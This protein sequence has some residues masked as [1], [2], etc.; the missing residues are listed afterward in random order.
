MGTVPRVSRVHRRGPP[1]GVPQSLCG[2]GDDELIVLLRSPRSQYKS[3]AALLLTSSRKA[4]CIPDA[5][6]SPW[7]GR[8]TLRSSR[9]R[10]GGHTTTGG[11]RVVRMKLDLVGG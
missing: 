2:S 11:S 10:L 3:I 9:T 1:A 7:L 4:S 8:N 6:V 5:I